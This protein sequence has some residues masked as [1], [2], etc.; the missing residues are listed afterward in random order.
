MNK[1]INKNKGVP[2]VNKVKVVKEPTVRQFFYINKQY[3]ED[4]IKTLE[5]IYKDTT[6]RIKE[7]E[8]IMKSKNIIF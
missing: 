6:K 3:N 2:V 5:R 1:N 4:L 7:W 8:E